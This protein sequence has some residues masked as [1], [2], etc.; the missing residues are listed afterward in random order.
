VAKLV[1]AYDSGDVDALVALLTRR[2]LRV[3][4]ATSPRMARPRRRGPLLRQ[5]LPQGPDV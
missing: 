1:R 5:L 3:H 2:C 4:A